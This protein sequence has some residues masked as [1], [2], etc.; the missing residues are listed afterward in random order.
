MLARVESRSRKY[1][2]QNRESEWM[3]PMHGVCGAFSQQEDK[4]EINQLL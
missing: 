4:K 2:C 1:A 3:Y